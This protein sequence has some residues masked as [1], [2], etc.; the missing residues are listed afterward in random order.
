MSQTTTLFVQIQSFEKTSFKMHFSVAATNSWLWFV[1]PRTPANDTHGPSRCRRRATSPPRF[2]I[3]RRQVELFG[4]GDGRVR[5][6]SVHFPDD[7]AH[8]RPRPTSL[9][10]SAL[11]GV[12]GTPALFPG[13]VSVT[14]RACAGSHDSGMC[15]K[16][17]AGMLSKVKAYFP[18][19]RLLGSGGRN[20]SISRTRAALVRKHCWLL[21]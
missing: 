5:P 13:F 7:R 15:G 19:N 17:T 6:D 14:N 11:P 2:Q 10:R 12:D 9:H 20:M 4:C 16:H 8:E 1:P 18:L 3:F 21:M